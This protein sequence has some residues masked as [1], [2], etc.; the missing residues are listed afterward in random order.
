MLQG[1]GSLSG[2]TDPQM[3]VS[4]ELTIKQARAAAQTTS[5][6]AAMA[7]IQATQFAVKTRQCKTD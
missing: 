7:T 1:L 6:C 4:A 3:N 2:Q 5:N